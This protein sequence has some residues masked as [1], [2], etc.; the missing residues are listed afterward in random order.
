[1]EMVF[2][3]LIFN[4]SKIVVFICL[5]LYLLLLPTITYWLRW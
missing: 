2:C 5:L 4:D 1:M 3:L